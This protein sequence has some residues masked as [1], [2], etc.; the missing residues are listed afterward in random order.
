MI[1][2]EKQGL[3]QL[4]KI[5]SPYLIYTTL[6][7]ILVLGLEELFGD[8]IYKISGQIGSVF[9]LAIA[10]F[11]GFRMNS[12]Y[13]RWW[14]A[15]K[16]FGELTNNSRS[17]VAKIYAYY[18]NDKNINLAALEKNAKIYDLIQLTIAY[19]RQ[20][21]NEIHNNPKPIFDEKSK[22][23][24]EKY[25]I[26]EEHKISNELLVS[27]SKEI[28]EDFKNTANIEKSDLMQHI[29]RFYDIQGKAERI[30]NTPFLMIYSAFT[31][32]IV[33]FYVVLIPLFIGDIDLGGEKSGLEFLA[34]P[35]M[36][37]ISTSFLTINKLANL[38][39]EPFSEN[40][41]SVTVTE[42]CN[43]IESNCKE[44]QSKLSV[45]N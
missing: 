35:I 13:D 14:E 25:N 40:K 27:I 17:F 6:Y 26:N 29:N 18:S 44:V 19:I 1:K 7:A 30:K 5:A 21:K 39:G 43:T 36:V 12:A 4:F 41:T 11:L 9:G 37:I 24:L 38:Y 3:L 28:E 10:F 16:I 32:I 23:L 34:I 33:S 20:F 2:T 31:K 15:R 45:K 8:H 22:V 42:I